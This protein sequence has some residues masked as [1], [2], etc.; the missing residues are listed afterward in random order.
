[1]NADEALKILNAHASTLVVPY[2]HWIG[3]K[4]ADQ[5]PSYCLPCAEAKVEAGEAEYVD[6]GWQQDND[7]C[8]HCDTCDRL[9]E[10]NLTDYGAAEELEHYL[11]NPPSAPISPEDAFHVAKML[12]HDESSPEA[13]AIAVAAAELIVLVKEAQP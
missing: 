3:G 11:A 6:G 7:G 12:K 1:M 9:L 5:G 2:P 13:V 10:Y 4:N 8:C